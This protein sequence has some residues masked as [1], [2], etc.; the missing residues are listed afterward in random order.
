MIR[1]E[2]L[3]ITVSASAANAGG[4]VT[5]TRPIHGEVIQIRNPSAALGAT[6]DYTLTRVSDG[7]TVFAGLDVAGPWQ[8]SP[9]LTTSLNSGTA[10]AGT[11]TTP[12]VPCCS[13]L[14]LVVGS[15]VASASGTLHIYYR[16]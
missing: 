9:V 10:L 5:T 13:H 12:G 3:P 8:F 6:A 15:A 16:D 14:Q 7:G 2:T 4:T 11:A 1:C